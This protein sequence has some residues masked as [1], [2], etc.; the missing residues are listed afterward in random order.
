M[1]QT[2]LI[3]RIWLA[4]FNNDPAPIS[5]LGPS[6]EEAKSVPAENIGSEDSNFTVSE[7]EEFESNGRRKLLLFVYSALSKKVLHSTFGGRG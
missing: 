3:V 5:G 2:G 6:A 7:E 1:Y 4:T